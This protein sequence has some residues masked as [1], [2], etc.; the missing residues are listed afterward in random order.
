MR[1]PYFDGPLVRGK[2]FYGRRRIV[3]DLLHSRHQCI[4]VVGN[5]RIGKTSLLYSLQEQ[6]ANVALY[7][8]LQGTNGDPV[9]IG[10]RFIDEANRKIPDLR[11][12]SGL[13]FCSALEK[14][15]R[16]ANDRKIDVLLLLDEAE[17]LLS[18]KDNYLQQLRWVLNQ[19][20]L[21]TILTASIWLFRVDSRSAAGTSPFLCG[22]SVNYLSPLEKQ[23]AQDLICQAQNPAGRV[24]VEKE[25]QTEIME[26]TGNHPFLIQHLCFSLFE[27]GC[28]RPITALDLVVDD[29]L[30]I[31][32]QSNYVMLSLP[33]QRILRELSA[34]DRK[35]IADLQQS[36][37]LQE[38]D[39]YRH[40]SSLE[41][42]GH[43]SLKEGSYRIANHFLRTWLL[44]QRPVEERELNVTTPPIEPAQRP[45]YTIH[46]E[47]AEG[48]AIGDGARVERAG[49]APAVGLP[50]PPAVSL[51]LLTPIFP[52]AASGHLDVT[53]FPWLT[54]TLDNLGRGGVEIRLRVS[55]GI[56]GYSDTAVAMATV[57][58]GNQARVDLLPLLK[59]AMVCQLNDIRPATLHVTV[60]QITPTRQILFDQT[61]RI[62]LLA[63]DTALLAVQ[64][65]GDT[66]TDLTRCL[67]AWVTPRHPEI[68]RL[69][70]Q[71]AEHH[72]D[73]QFV[74]YQGTSSEEVATIV[75][76][77]ARAI[78]TTLQ[79]EANIVYINSP[80]SLGAQQG[81][82][83]QRVRLPTESLAAGG[84]AN[85]IDGTVLFASLL[86]LAAIDPLIVIIPGHAFVGW[87]IWERVNRY[88]FLETTM[89]GSDSFGAAQEAAQALYEEAQSRGHFGRGLFEPAG[90]ARLIDVRECRGTGIYPLE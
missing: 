75:R 9:R 43:I 80:L 74:G 87:R 42:L 2:D 57:P 41:K 47:H 88:E 5:R 19:P 36:L 45:T 33:Q 73:R 4:Y 64:S 78:F 46:I 62:H 68:E 66:I 58:P 84:S 22:F 85:C 3:Q 31:V 82:I 52:T 26:L 90:F 17:A 1:N 30:D 13:D 81:Q 51:A 6:C 20:S 15:A 38:D 59:P 55:A 69:L 71:A 24:Q 35:D 34:C 10:E 16:V 48:L 23:E 61:K 50:A 86:E 18:L 28:L 40:L 44:C 12:G 77:Q 32:F 67:A 70:R 65:P 56:E 83:A 14:T 89:I 37:E 63:R 54:V 11:L 49:T 53:S 8:S 79:R 7:L 39:L 21:R 76:E 60:E 29:V 25:L 72:P 27:E